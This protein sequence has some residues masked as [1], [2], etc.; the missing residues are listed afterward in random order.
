MT[1]SLS[2]A[3]L[4]ITHARPAQAQLLVPPAIL[5]TTVPLT[6]RP[7]FAVA[8]P[9]IMTWELSCVRPAIQVALLAR[10]LGRA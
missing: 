7:T 5:P 9:S 8:W 3:C 10:L 2:T 6:V 4:A 1:H